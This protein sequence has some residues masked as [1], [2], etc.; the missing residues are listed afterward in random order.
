MQNKLEKF[1]LGISGLLASALVVAGFKIN[2][3]QKK[4]QKLAQEN[5]DQTDNAQAI[6]NSIQDKRD[7]K[8]NAAAHAPLENSNTQVTTKTVIPGKTIT[9]TVPGTSS[10]KSSSSSSSSSKTTKTS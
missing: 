9:Q 4:M 1:L 6:Q 5:Q 2:D 7:S 3:D 10:S 8:L